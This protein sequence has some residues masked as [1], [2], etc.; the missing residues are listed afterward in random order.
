MNNFPSL[1]FIRI[2]IM[3]SHYS[4]GIDYM[5]VLTGFAWVWIIWTSLKIIGQFNSL[6]DFLESAAS[7]CGE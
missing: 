4:Q 7:E 2:S 6:F 1:K 3:F 5:C